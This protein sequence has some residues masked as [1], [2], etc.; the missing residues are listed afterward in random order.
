MKGATRLMPSPAPASQPG[1][2][3]LSVGRRSAGGLGR[4]QLRLLNGSTDG[5]LIFTCRWDQTLPFL[6]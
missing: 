5:I 6:T 3:G 2:S 4:P 1:G